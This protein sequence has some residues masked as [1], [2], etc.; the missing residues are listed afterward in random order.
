MQDLASKFHLDRRL[1]R[2]RDWIV[3][4][5]LEKELTRL[6]DVSEKAELIESPQL[7]NA[8]SEPAP[9]GGE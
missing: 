3:P 8:D 4:E 2:R 1:Q 7:P 5:Q 6:A 9:G